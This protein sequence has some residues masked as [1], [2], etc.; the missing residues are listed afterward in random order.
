[1]RHMALNAHRSRSL[2]LIALAAGLWV[3][4]TLAASQGAA[5]AGQ[6]GGALVD[7]QRQVQPILE[8]SCSECHS[9]ERRKGGLSL[10]TYADILEGGRNGAVVRPGNSANSLIVHRLTG[11]TEPQMPKDEVPLD[12][13]SI[14]LIRLWIDE[15]ARATPTSAPAPP[16]WEAPLTLERPATPAVTWREWTSTI[17]RFAADYMATRQAAEPTLVSDALFARRVYLDIWGLLP[18]P[19]ELRAF[20]DD[21]TPTKRETLVATLLAD[22]KKYADHWISF[23]NDLLRNEDG[24]TYFSESASRKSITD[25]LQPA[26]T[27]NLPYNR[28]V[29]KLINPSAPGDPEGF[30]IGVNWRGET[31]AAVTPWM[32]AS[33]NTAQVFLGVN[34][35]CNA[36]H[37]SFVSKW[38][39]KDAYSLAGFFSPE[40]RLRMY[41]CDVAQDAYAEPGF[42]YPE[43]NRVP[44]STALPDRR[45]TAAAIFTDPRNGRLP[46][47]LVNRIWQRLLGHGIVANPDEMDGKPWSPGLLDAL[48]SD[49]V[50]HNY[51]LKYLIH[52]IVTSRTYQMPAVSR[53]AE[54]QARGYVFEGPEVRRLSAEQFADAVGSITGEWSVYPT[55][56]GGGGEGRGEPPP[57]DPP[58]AGAYG[59]E[60]RA[61]SSNLTR[62]LGRP[63]RDQITSSRPTQ[64]TTPQALELVNGEMLTRSLSRGARRMIGELPPERLS[65]YNKTVA[66]RNASASAFDIDISKATRLWLVAEDYGSNAPERVEP[67]WSSAELV[68]ASGKSTTLAS[69]KPVEA[70][71]LRSSSGSPAAGKDGS[72]RVR[73]PSR[74]VYDVKGKGFVRFR[75]SIAL[76]N[77]RS[78]IGATLNPAIRFYVFDSQPNMDRLLPPAPQPPLPP[79]PTVPTVANAVD[80][81]FMHALG[82]AP[83][84]AERRLAVS[85]IADPAR[86]GRASAEGLADL[87]WAVLMKPEFQLI[88]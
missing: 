71:G 41:R 81:V 23:W 84:S 55:R 42:L 6:A 1:M 59:R 50:E 16:P 67:L 51:D 82:R 25:W 31:S 8:S 69:L 43:L 87:L 7:F 46:R 33:Q 2:A 48:A 52:A 76:D 35:K 83:S 53:S 73:A 62:A 54:V 61:A 78:D 24:V 85:A 18:R 5:A 20:L 45:A 64:A 63:I 12:A 49:F 4:A 57:T 28:F 38:K 14:A 39:L 37:D 44:P 72:V 58:T 22:D 26:L 10:A 17:D 13:A 70:Q 68:D 47:T 74:L 77:P 75:G 30:L 65:L 9:Q 36:C 66:G 29:D 88:Y 11:A 27:S 15:G 80:R 86:P 19:E 40:A 60:W 34:L 21:R 32:Q 79:E 3:A 56:G